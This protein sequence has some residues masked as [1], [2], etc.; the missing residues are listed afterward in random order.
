[1]NRYYDMEVSARAARLCLRQVAKLADEGTVGE[2]MEAETH[3]KVML[4]IATVDD[5]IAAIHAAKARDYEIAQL[6][7]MTTE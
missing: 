4:A 3:M 1:M 6:E 2:A 7:E 5:T